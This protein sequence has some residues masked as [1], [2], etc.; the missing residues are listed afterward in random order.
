MNER[1]VNIASKTS[2]QAGDAS[3]CG[4]TPARRE[5]SSR[6][7]IIAIHRTLGNQAV[8]RLF[9]SRGLQPK[10]SIGKPNDIYEQEADRVADHIMRMPEKKVDGNT[11]D[12]T[13]CI[14]QST[15]QLKPG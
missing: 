15:I 2:E 12:S 5:P 14:A 13:S 8:Q 1:S 7:R 6:D 3:A 4:S 10:L 11:I 9:Q